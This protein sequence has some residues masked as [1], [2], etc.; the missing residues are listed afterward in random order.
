MLSH[1]PL[2]DMLIL[3]V[4]QV[5]QKGKQTKKTP[6][7]GRAFEPCSPLLSTYYVPKSA[8]AYRTLTLSIGVDV[9]THNEVF[10]RSPLSSHSV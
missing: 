8:L 9:T 3:V 4:Q 1:D 2:T 6:K 7:H 10:R 5:N